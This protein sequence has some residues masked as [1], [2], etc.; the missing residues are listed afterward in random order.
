V[1][2]EQLL[3][4]RLRHLRKGQL[5]L[6]PHRPGVLPDP[7]PD[8]AYGLYV[9]VPFCEV[10]CPY[11]SFNRFAF[12]HHDATRYFANLRDELRLLRDRG[13]R[14]SSLY[15]GGGTPT[16][17]LDELT[18]TI[19]LARELFEIG[20]VSTETNPNHLTPELCDEL[21]GRVQRL[22]VGV[23]SLDDEV[24]RRMSRLERYG[25][26][27]QIL[28][29]LDGIRGRFPT[30]NVDMIFNLPSLGDA[31]LARD[32]AILVETPIDQITYYPLMVS[33]SVAGPLQRALGSVDYRREARQYRLISRTLH[34]FGR[35]TS[36]WSFSRGEATAID[37]YVVTHPEYV[38]IGSG[39]FSYLAGELYANTFSLAQYA[40]AISRGRLSVDARMPL[41]RRDALRY[42]FMMR[43][44]G[45]QLDKAAFAAQHG[46]GALDMLLP[47]RLFMRA[48][49]AFERDDTVIT[50]T[51][52][53]RYLLVVMMREFF[54]GV[55]GVRDLARAA[56]PEEERLAASA[57]LGGCA[58]RPVGALGF[59][60]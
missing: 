5:R 24:L 20:D 56:L 43:L 22:S 17:L 57:D 33:P 54:I 10:L 51:E 46:A 47:E 49:G 60:D 44:F 31:S 58:V 23:Q 37:E 38:G 28:E 48:S 39:S 11:C 30:L 1:I 25:S 9:H 27:A 21:E 13:Y 35:P 45:L 55:N 40:E 29:R 3:R 42:D 32:L 41:R 4:R 16:V 52:T 18:R 59:G 34:E 36:A 53:G 26:S 12:K 7:D 19:D 6:E 2:A 15:I 14:C 50:L 8:V